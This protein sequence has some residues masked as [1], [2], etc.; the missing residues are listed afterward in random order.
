VKISTPVLLSSALASVL[1]LSAAPDLS[2]FQIDPR[3][4]I[5]LFAAEPDIVDPVALTFDESGRM[6]VI[7]MRDYPYGVGPDNKPGG[8][9]RLLEDTNRDGKADKSTLFAR[10]LSFPTSIA[11]WKGG[12]FVTAPPDI[13][14][15]KDTNDD[16]VAD[17]RE[18]FFTGFVLG[19]TDS[20]ANGLRWGL[21][22]LLHGLNGGNGGRI[23]APSRPQLSVELGNAD[24][25]IDPVKRDLTPTYQSSGGFGLVFDEFGRSFVTHNINHIQQR[26]LPLPYLW[27]APGMFPVDATRSISDHGDMARIFPISVAQTRPNHPEQAGHFSSAGGLGYIGYDAYPADLYRSITVGDVVGNLIHRDVLQTNGPIFSAQ[28]HTSETNREFIASTDPNARLVGLELG[29]DGALYMIDMQRDV[30]EHPDYIPEKMRKNQDIRAG[31]DRGRIYRITPKGGLPRAEV[32]LAKASPRELV[33]ELQH[34]NMWRRQTAQRLLIEREAKSV[35]A[36]LVGLTRS[37][38]APARVHALWTL[39]GLNAIQPHSLH[40]RFRDE[41][42]GV[43]E[44]ALRIFETITPPTYDRSWRSGISLLST[45]PSPAVRFQLA[46]TLGNLEDIQF[47]QNTLLKLLITDR[48]DYWIRIAAL[49]SLRDPAG[50]LPKVLTELSTNN[51]S[52]TLNLVRDLADLAIARVQQPAGQVVEVVNALED[53]PNPIILAGL[54]GL[55]RGLA[56]KQLTPTR[57]AIQPVLT[58]IAQ[59]SDPLFVAAW[60]IGKRL[61]LPQTAE[62]KSALESAKNSASNPSAARADRLRAIDR[63]RFGSYSDV[64]DALLANIA[65][66]TDAELQSAALNVLRSFRDEDLATQLVARWPVLAPSLQINVLNFLLSRRSFH[67]ALVTGIEKGDLKLGELNLDL[68][69]RRTLLREST[70]EIHARAAKFIG[71]EEYSNRKQVLD[72]WLAKLPPNG[73]PVA[74]RPVFEQ[75]CAQ[76]HR[77]SDL[78]KNVGP[79]LTSISH[80]SV[81]DILY[82]IID[83]NMAINPLY[84]NYQ[85]ETTSGDLHNGILI[86]ESPDSITLLQAQEIKTTIPRA[87]ITK[88][89]STG[90]SLM[91][92]SLESTLTPQQMRDLISFLQNPATTP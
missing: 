23:T 38:F 60:K 66:G 52:G 33:L 13:L 75:L 20:N 45:D 3:L 72:D 53:S 28:R 1:T 47:A 34:H 29:P 44:N 79:D 14:Y 27:R 10:D 48:D 77:A 56:R 86:A 4:E 22:N 59:R 9:I 39:R 46:L 83:P 87:D 55:D 68:E 89:R 37:K 74:G 11:P 35:T 31:D 26:I 36:Q 71:D 54:D 76:C 17:I 51:S 92:E 84:S 25:A 73:D 19:V 7:E 30:I 40:E 16:G 90:T 42:P 63:L 88:L 50:T 81:E 69:Q 67:D 57:L 65:E 85:V 15:L 64:R 78:G 49:S 43:R 70:P 21:D 2:T 12:V 32:D 80:R 18:V 58:R 8:T 91:P 6:Y 24:F 61:N 41:D 5:A 82:N 62:Q